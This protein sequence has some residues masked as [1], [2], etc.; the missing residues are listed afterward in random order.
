ML[1]L[2]MA[3]SIISISYTYYTYGSEYREYKRLGTI[4][5]YYI[6][7]VLSDR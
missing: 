5:F 3:A 6:D 2:L 1:A 7:Y 4:S